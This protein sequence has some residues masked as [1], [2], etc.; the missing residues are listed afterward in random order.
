MIEIMAKAICECEGHP[1][2]KCDG[3]I[4]TFGAIDGRGRV[5]KRK[6]RCPYLNDAEAVQAAL[7]N[8]TDAMTRAGASVPIPM[9]TPN[10][11]A[12][13]LVWQA[14]VDAMETET[15]GDG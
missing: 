15:A 5:V 9:S 7:R 2:T 6:R 11:D 14:N 8:P 12:S 4:Q 1:C 10:K 13:V 3:R